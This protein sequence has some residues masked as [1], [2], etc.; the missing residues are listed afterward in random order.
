MACWS[1]PQLGAD[2]EAPWSGSGTR[3][4]GPCHRTTYRHN[5]PPCQRVHD[6]V[7]YTRGSR[8]G[9]VLERAEGTAAFGLIWNWSTDEV[10][11]YIARRQLPVNP[12]Y[13]KLTERSTDTVRLTLATKSRS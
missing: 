4:R 2:E 7:L 9:A 10:R 1:G 13:A 5:R 3:V 8:A 11:S 6:R 12:V